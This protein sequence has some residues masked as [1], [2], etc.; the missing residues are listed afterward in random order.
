MSRL[1]RSAASAEERRWPGR[2]VVVQ[3]DGELP[4]VRA[5]EAYVRQVLR[6]LIAN[7]LG[8]SPAG[9]PVDV[10]ISRGDG[11]V[12]TRILDRSQGIQTE[13]GE[14]AFGLY[15]RSPSVAARVAGTGIGLFVAK[16]LVEALRGRIWLVGRPGGGQEI[17][18]TLPVA[19]ADAA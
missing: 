6:N 18:F 11:V 2:R 10:V 4:A 8:G 16:L 5:D 15:H 3:V 14:D 13:A 19:P 17:T 1:V 9:D 7:A 12:V